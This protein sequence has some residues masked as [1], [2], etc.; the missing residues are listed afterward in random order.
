[1]DGSQKKWEAEI[2]SVRLTI[3]EIHSNRQSGSILYKSP[4]G[5]ARKAVLLSSYKTPQSNYTLK[6]VTL[7]FVV[8]EIFD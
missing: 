2:L 4:Q 6:F 7:A 1:M 8:L 5:G 3:Q